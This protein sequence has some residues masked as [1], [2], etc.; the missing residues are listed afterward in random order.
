M[1]TVDELLKTR[2]D[3]RQVITL[4]HGIVDWSDRKEWLRLEVLRNL[5]FNEFRVSNVDVGLD[6]ISCEFSN[7]LFKDMRVENHFWG[8]SDIWQSC[9]F[10]DCQM[11]GMIAPMNSFRDCRFHKLRLHNFKPHQTLFT[12]TEFENCTIQGLRAKTI[13]NKG[14]INTDIT[15]SHGQLLFLDCTFLNVEFRQCYFQDVVFERCKWEGTTADECC[16]DGVVS[17]LEWWQTQR[18]D[19]FTGFLSDALELI[20]RKCGH[21][22]AAYKEFENYLIDYGAGRTSNRDFSACL[23]NNRVPYA[24]T[25]KIIKD[26]RKLVDLHPF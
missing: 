10:E 24:E 2:G 8:S 6:F 13:R 15:S 23:Y 20:R 4:P 16:F 18:L 9:V 3:V 12:G 17:D 25:Q 7:C 5:E 11:S 19:P 1:V 21:E 22:S 26:L 14:V